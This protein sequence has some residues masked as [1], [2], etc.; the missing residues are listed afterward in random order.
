MKLK[1]KA[2][3]SIHTA[4]VN[5]LISN[6]KFCASIQAVRIALGASNQVQAGD[7]LLVDIQAEF[8]VLTPQPCSY[9]K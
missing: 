2:N 8:I 3:K 7:R 6:E 9:A 5:R 4:F 1:S